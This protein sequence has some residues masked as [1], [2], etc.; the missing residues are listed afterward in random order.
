MRQ[1]GVAMPAVSLY[2]D[3]KTHGVPGLSDIGPHAALP[4]MEG[5][6]MLFKAISQNES[7]SCT[8]SPLVGEGWDGG[9]GGARLSVPY[10][11]FHPHPRPPPSRGR[12]S[13]RENLYQKSPKMFGRVELHQSTGT[14]TMLAAV[15]LCMRRV[16]TDERYSEVPNASYTPCLRHAHR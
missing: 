11:P 5:K 10:A 8:P 1:G 9:T 2:P 12:E 13:R 15:L 6:A 14:A 3:S 16:D 7:P 4:V